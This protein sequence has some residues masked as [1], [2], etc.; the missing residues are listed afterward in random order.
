MGAAASSPVDTEPPVPLASA[1]VSSSPSSVGS[2]LIAVLERP[3]GGLVATIGETLLARNLSRDISL[4][5]SSVGVASPEYSLT[6]DGR[7]PEEQLRE[8]AF[9]G[10]DALLKQLMVR[11]DGT[12]PSS[13]E[14]LA[15]A[16]ALLHLIADSIAAGGRELLTHEV[17]AQMAVRPG[18]ASAVATSFAAEAAEALADSGLAAYVL[19]PDGDGGAPEIAW[20]D[21]GGA[22]V[23]RLPLAFSLVCQSEE[24]M[25]ATLEAAAAEAAS[26]PPPPQPQPPPVS[27]PQE[28]A[29]EATPSETPPPP[30]PPPVPPPPPPPPSRQV[31]AERFLRALSSCANA[32]IDEEQHRQEEAE[33]AAAE[34]AA[35]EAEAARR[36]AAAAARAAEDEAR[37]RRQAVSQRQGG[38]AVA[39]R[40]VPVPVPGGVWP[41][42][43]APTPPTVRGGVPPLANP[44]GLSGRIA[45]AESAAASAAASAH[46]GRAAIGG[47]G[48]G[49]ARAPGGWAAAPVSAPGMRPAAP[50]AAPPSSSSSSGRRF[51]FATSWSARGN[52]YGGGQSGG[53]APPCAPAAHRRSPLNMSSATDGGVAL[54]SRTGG[55]TFFPGGMFG[56]PYN[57]SARAAPMATGFKPAGMMGVGYTLR[58]RDISRT[59]SGGGGVVSSVS[60]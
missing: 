47:G 17:A 23:G 40:P 10:R 18:G 1:P 6:E 39:S 35:A 29:G 2:W 15:A 43:A 19:S 33:R 34:A 49:V 30:P 59:S 27:P 24:L 51:S 25:F 52:S 21:D 20:A 54:T 28:K 11:T 57:Y 37:T 58:D 9:C 3:S 26:P 56:G 8:V 14:E 36:A 48:G 45:A 22:L 53:E 16:P 41:P 12:V 60:V 5:R 7:T 31:R 4:R 46:G 55:A 42:A 38:A 13:P 32:A 44:G 50:S